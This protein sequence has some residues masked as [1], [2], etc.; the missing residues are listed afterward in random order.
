[1]LTLPPCSLPSAEGTRFRFGFDPKTNDYKVVKL[2]LF[3]SHYILPQVEFME[4]VCIRL[5]RSYWL[6]ILIGFRLSSL[7][8]LSQHPNFKMV[9]SIPMAAAVMSI[10]YYVLQFIF[11]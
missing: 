5:S 6:V 10:W 3:K 8:K 4:M 7:V 9:S 2:N 11:P 1:M